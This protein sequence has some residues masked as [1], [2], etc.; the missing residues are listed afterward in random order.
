[1][2]D[3][4]PD[5]PSKSQKKRDMESL[6]QL[7]RALAELPGDYLNRV[8]DPQIREAV[9]AARKI[10]KGNARKRQLQYVAKLLA[11]TD[12][13]P[14]QSIVESLDASSAEYNKKFHQLERWREQLIEGSQQALSEILDAH[15]D[16]DRQQL[17]QLI[18]KATQERESGEQLVYFRRLFQFLKQLED[19]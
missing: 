10:T 15:P 12:V 16:A 19:T 3:D 11:R 8:D 5:K 14:I 7:A 13:T 4:A 9:L 2:T 17:R 1:M 6:R 18:R